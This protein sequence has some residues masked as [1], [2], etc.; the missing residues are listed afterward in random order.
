MP[1]PP[2]PSI[3]ATPPPSTCTTS[4]ISCPPPFILL[5]PYSI[6]IVVSRRDPST[7]IKNICFLFMTLFFLLWKPRRTKVK[8]KLRKMMMKNF[9]FLW[10]ILQI[11]NFD[12][13]HFNLFW[14]WKRSFQF[15][16]MKYFWRYKWDFE[17]MLK[18]LLFLKKSKCFRKKRGFAIRLL[19]LDPLKIED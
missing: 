17:D 1:H 11:V 18:F 13:K 2:L 16:F 12:H 10:K 15:C 8:K 5:I 3:C 19:S 4:S 6:F 7:P 9:N 14:R